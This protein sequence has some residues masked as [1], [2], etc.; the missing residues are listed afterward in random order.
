MKAYKTPMPYAV[1]RT[2][3]ELD[4]VANAPTGDQLAY[5]HAHTAVTNGDWQLSAQVLDILT[6]LL[7]A[8][9]A[10]FPFIRSARIANLQF[11]CGQVARLV[12]I[13]YQ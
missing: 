1:H 11:Y 13:S 6:T 9:D 4:Q 3:I 8:V 5:E 12:R 2:L 7:D 10:A